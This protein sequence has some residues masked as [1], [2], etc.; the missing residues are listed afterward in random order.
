MTD[1]QPRA[2]SGVRSAAAIL[3]W[4]LPVFAIAT[5]TDQGGRLLLSLV[6]AAI[7]GP[8]RFG[9]WVV[10]ALIIQYA[11]FGSAGVPQGAGR[12]IPRLL[13]AGN[14]AGAA[15]IEDHA[16]AGSLVSGIAV[17]ALSLILVPLLLGGPGTVPPT[18][19]ALLA[20]CVVLQQLFLL[21]QVLLR[22]R[23]R[24]RH[25]S[26]QLVAQ[27]VVAPIAG[28]GL[29]V[30]GWGVDGLLVSRA[31]V[32]GVALVAG[33]RTLAR[34]PQP[35]WDGRAIRIL[36]RIG[37]PLVAAG[38]L[39]L[40]LVTIDRSIVA[41]LLGREAAGWY[42]IV[43]LAL[44]GLLIFP[45][46]ISQQF[47]PRLAGARGA[48]VAPSELLRL[49]RQQGLLA[50]V[51][52]GVAAVLAA[53]A[54]MTI[55]PI[56]LPAYVPAVRPIVIVSVGVAVFAFASGD[57]NL[58]NLLDRQRHYLSIQAAT[59]VLDVA[60]AVVLIRLGFGIDGVAAATATAMALY[61]LVLHVA[62]ARAASDASPAAADVPPSEAG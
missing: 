38:T 6:A 31:I 52:T 24:F 60:A 27:G 58:L 62:A 55:L 53:I 3:G 1:E 28:I 18:T 19:Y 35:A 30:L 5:F 4:D 25:A 10:L 20:I 50:G 16:A 39:F 12:E 33:T 43:G 59:L 15:R 2:R 42:G 14:E 29:L 21:E 48:G 56:V 45:V 32:L 8:A 11:S 61:G 26:A 51:V 40:V 23:L 57:G 37:L 7:L 41:A 49:A 13:G 17:G 22:S 44:S 47:Y 36:A 34:V 46:L 9:E 54:A